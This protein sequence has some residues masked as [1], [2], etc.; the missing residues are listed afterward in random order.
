MNE[1]TKKNCYKC[2]LE[3]IFNN[4]SQYFLINL[5]DLEG[6]TESNW[7]NIFNRQGNSSTLKYRV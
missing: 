7:L 4:D 6:E 1:I 2:D 5:R 3:I